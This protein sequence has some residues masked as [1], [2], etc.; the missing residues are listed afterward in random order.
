M[1][2]QKLREYIRSLKNDR[3][4]VK[5]TVMELESVH[6]DPMS[7]EPRRT[8]EA[9]RL[10][11][12]NAVLMQELMAMKVGNKCCRI[13]HHPFWANFLFFPYLSLLALKPDGCVGVLKR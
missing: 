2:E 1:D 7:H 8:P 12:E 11:L 10:D 3:A 5:T 13:M 6:I 4:S 9:Q